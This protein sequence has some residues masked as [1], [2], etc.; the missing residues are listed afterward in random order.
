MLR[1]ALSTCRRC[2]GSPISN[3]NL[4]SATRSRLVLTVADRILT[5]CSEMAL[6]TSDSRPVRSSASTWIAARN[7]ELS[8]GDQCTETTRS[9]SDWTRCCT[10]TQS[11][12]CT[13]TPL[14]LVTKPV[15]LSPG[16]G[17]QH[18]DN[19]AQTSPAPSTET[20]E[21]PGASCGLGGLV[22][23]VGSA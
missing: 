10:F 11:A 16:T 7:L 4:L 17:V 12:R 2:S 13:E 22:R 9:G 21:S 20:P 6:V 1:T 15:I 19:R 14:P 5:C 18:L 8:L 3:V 23:L